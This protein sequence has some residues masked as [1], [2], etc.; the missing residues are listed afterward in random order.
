MESN[1]GATRGT[2]NPE[3]L[4]CGPGV[5]VP[6]DPQWVAGASVRQPWLMSIGR[7]PEAGSRSRDQRHR[8]AVVGLGSQVNVNPNESQPVT[9]R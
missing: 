2:V 9:S 3:V 1:A 4:R 7:G 8:V 6:A 5:N